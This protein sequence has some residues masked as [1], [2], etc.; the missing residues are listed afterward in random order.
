[1]RFKT[2]LILLIVFAVLLAVVLF[3][4]KEQTKKEE[5]E[6]EAKRLLNLKKADI[7]EVFLPHQNIH[8]IKEGDQWKI[9]SP[10]ETD[11]DKSAIEGMFGMFS[12]AKIERT[13]SEDTSEFSNFG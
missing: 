2:T 5:I 10:I 3:I 6:K 9:L 11:G 12:W 7:T 13:M 8:A 4:N 1:M